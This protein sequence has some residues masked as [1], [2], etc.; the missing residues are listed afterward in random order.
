IPWLHGK[1]IKLK[2]RRSGVCSF[3][4]R[5]SRIFIISTGAKYYVE[6]D[7]IDFGG[8]TSLPAFS[9]TGQGCPGF[10][11]GRLQGAVRRGIARARRVLGAPGPR[12]SGLEQ[13]VHQ[14]ARRVRGYFLQVVRRW[15]TERFGQLPR[16]ALKYSRTRYT[17]NYFRH[18]GNAA[19]RKKGS[20]YVS[21]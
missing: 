14:S 19:S 18:I 13:A 17:G 6:R 20:T 5:F 15:R 11:H 8:E 9:R 12:E 3:V 16:S 21:K 4:F 7:R 2:Y 10:R 1:T